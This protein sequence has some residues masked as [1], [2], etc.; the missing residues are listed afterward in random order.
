MTRDRMREH[1]AGHHAVIRQQECPACI[2][3]DQLAPRGASP[4]GRLHTDLVRAW[5]AEPVQQLP[6]RNGHTR[7]LRGW[8]RGILSRS[9]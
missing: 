1:L 8:L 3:A 2:S 9:R 7:G 6:A 5:L 4:A